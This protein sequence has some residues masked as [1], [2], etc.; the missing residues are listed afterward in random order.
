MP[1]GARRWRWHVVM[2]ASQ[3]INQSISESESIYRPAV[4]A[5][6]PPSCAVA[7]FAVAAATEAPGEAAI[8]QD[9]QLPCAE[10]RVAVA[11]APH[12]RP[13]KLYL[14]NGRNSQ[15]AGVNN[16]PPRPGPSRSR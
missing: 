12:K 4:E 15:P 9:E 8:R 13:C 10:P 14:G 1:F 11:A 2:C 5:A 6:P 7:A 16:S 3:S